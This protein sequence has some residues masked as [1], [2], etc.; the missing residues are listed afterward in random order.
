MTTIDLARCR[1]PACHAEAL[2]TRVRETDITRIQA[3]AIACRACGAEYDILWGVPLLGCY[4]E[5]DVLGLIEIAA[6]ANNYRRRRREP[7]ADA[8]TDRWL[9]LLEDFHHAADKGNA[10]FV[11]HQIPDEA[12][13]WFPNR[14]AEHVLFRIMTSDLT[15]AGKDV[16]DVGAGTGFD[17]RRFVRAGAR[18]TAFDYSP[19]LAHEGL[20]NVPEAR[21]FCGTMPVLPFAERSF[22]VVV[23]NAALHHMKDVSGSIE[24]MLRVVRPGGHIL[25][26]CDSFR[27]D[28]SPPE[29]LLEI[30]GDDPAVL[31]GVNE[32]VPRIGEFLEPF[33]RHGT[34][35]EVRIVT[36][37]VRGAGLAAD[38]LREWTLAEARRMLERAG[39][40][41]AIR[42]R[43]RTSLRTQPRFPPREVIRPAAF[44]NALDKESGAVA[45]IAGRLP[46]DLTNLPLMGD[47]HAWFRLLNGWKPRRPG[48]RHRVC[49]GRAR[50]FLSDVPTDAGLTVELLVPHCPGIANADVE[51]VID[52]QTKMR[53][54]LCRGLW[55][56]LRLDWPATARGRTVAV[57]VR[58]ARDEAEAGSPV[59]LVRRLEIGPDQQAGEAFEPGLA[60]LEQSGLPALRAL[61]LLGSARAFVIFSTDYALGVEVLNRLRE[62]ELA[63]DAV[64]PASQAAIYR[65]ERSVR[66]VGTYADRAQ[67]ARLEAA[68]SAES[69]LIV[70]T[71]SREAAR[72][73]RLLPLAPSVPSFAVSTGGFAVDLAAAT[74]TRRTEPAI[75]RSAELR[76]AMRCVLA[77]M[78]FGD[79]LLS[80]RRAMLS[81]GHG[82]RG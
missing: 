8:G 43:L 2:D 16:L 17:S 72:L 39:G 63:C 47:E 13:S 76:A 19:V 77:S 75:A 18:V 80:L 55:T 20:H 66:I 64:V 82:Y 69:I 38:D 61:G 46:R 35:L 3:G 81:R 51:I 7:A 57:E 26:L 6:N 79:R 42:T 21:W 59:F 73:R 65:T 9:D 34:E 37:H 28:D 52:G 58:L 70:A 54:T 78:P 24:E 25:T 74:A 60:R 33:E 56:R 4:G 48:E 5:E 50:A 10:F 29:A 45:T 49:H 40:T 27:A 30:F 41:I 71:D 67:N 32:G 12:R 31:A 36:S 62:M 23:V 44:A 1:C 53:E 22:D 15:L 68:L 14:Y 11:R